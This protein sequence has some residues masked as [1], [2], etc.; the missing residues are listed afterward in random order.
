MA[1]D[2]VVNG[3][4]QQRG[5]Q[6]CPRKIWEGKGLTAL[7]SYLPPFV[8]VVSPGRLGLTLAIDSKGLAQRQLTWVAPGR[9]KRL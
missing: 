9:E 8:I 4:G 7:L 6:R 3:G 2:D 1:D 5:G